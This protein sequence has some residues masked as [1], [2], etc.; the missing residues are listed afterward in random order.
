ML[1]TRRQ[2][3][4]S[5]ADNWTTALVNCAGDLAEIATDRA[6]LADGTVEQ[7]ARSSF[8]TSAG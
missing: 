3:G 1:A 5:R 4:T 7:R 6:E 8:R 2:F